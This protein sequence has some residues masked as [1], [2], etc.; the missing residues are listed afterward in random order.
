M[1]TKQNI[2]MLLRQD[3]FRNLTQKKLKKQGKPE[4]FCCAY[5]EYREENGATG[6]PG[7]VLHTQKL[8]MGDRLYGVPVRY[9]FRPS[10]YRVKEEVWQQMGSLNMKTKTVLGG[11]YFIVHC[12]EIQKSI[13]EGRLPMFVCHELGSAYGAYLLGLPYVL[14]YHQQGSILNEI[15]AINEEPCEEDIRVIHFI[16]AEVMKGA[17]KV[18]FPSFGARKFFLDT[19]TL[20]EEEAG[21]VP[22]ANDAL[23]NTIP[24]YG[25][26]EDK[27]TLFE[28]F[29]IELEGTEELFLSI[30]DYNHDKGM[31]LIPEFLQAYAAKSGRKVA[32]IA[33]GQAITGEIFRKM[34]EESETWNFKAFLFDQRISHDQ[35]LGFLTNT[36]CYIMLHR[37]SVFDIATLEAM[38]AG[39]GLVLSD[40][41]SN[42]EFNRDG[43]VVIVRKPGDEEAVRRLEEIDRKRWRHSNRQVFERYFSQGRFRE[44][45][46]RMLEAFL[47]NRCGKKQSEVN[48]IYLS[49]WKDRYKGKKVIICG[50]GSSLDNLKE[51]E[52]ECIYIALNKA[53]FYP[54]IQFDVLFMQDMPVGQKHTLED[55]NR[56][57]CTKFYGI[58]TNP[59][60]GSM[61][62]G[63]KDAVF[64]EVEGEVCRYELCPQVFRFQ[65]EQVE[66]DIGT[67][68][69]SDAQSVLFS[70]LQFAVFAGADKIALCGVDFSDTNYGNR[71]NQ[72]HYARNVMN[73]LITFKRQI[74]ERHPGLDFYF[75]HTCNEALDKAFYAIDHE[76]E[77]I[78]VSGIYTDNYFDMVRLQEKT[79]RDSFQFDFRHISD[80]EWNRQKSSGSF[81][82]FDGNTIKT[83]LVIDKIKEYWGKCLIVADADLVFFRKTKEQL[84]YELRDV[85]MLF[86]RERLDENNL[87]ERAPANVNIGFVCMRCNEHSLMFWEEVQ[88]KVVQCNGWDQ[89]IANELLLENPQKWN[90]RLLSERFLNGGDINGANIKEQM[91]CTS[92]GT[93]ARRKGFDKYDFLWKAYQFSQEQKWFDPEVQ[94]V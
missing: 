78:V 34:M 92:C 54:R 62:V 82:F 42:H 16:E 50:A 58:I 17:D 88:R 44:K 52:K 63:G 43:N 35:V 11:A 57:P 32:W 48:Q 10:G 3:E 94:N 26:T 15:K 89:E 20:S 59:D 1:E 51:Q 77:E 33:F 30:G 29:G 73:N 9:I 4:I 93:V 45:Y 69:L 80:E 71:E 39:C 22:F 91:I 19:C 61:G 79:C 75:L 90:Y 68:A 55:Y 47:N 46:G 27:K 38:Y 6:G 36:D 56:Y 81:A 14:I 76:E 21:E 8:L 67:Y 83:Q 5:R 31:D 41:G 7:G 84:L 49:G 60:F 25:L 65:T 2:D 18:Y 24:D 74:K 66:T 53:L 28:K 87:Y 64:H 13:E 40:A 72:S 12:E 23:Y 70:A 37:N 85:D 86:L